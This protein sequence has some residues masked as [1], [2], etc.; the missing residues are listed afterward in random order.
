MFELRKCEKASNAFSM[1]I[2]VGRTEN[3]DV[4]VFDN[5]VSR[6]HAYFQQDRK[7]GQWMLVDAESLNGTWVGETRLEPSRPTP[8]SGRATLRF[9]EVQMLFLSPD[10]FASHLEAQV[11]AG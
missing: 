7:T 6:F 9:G 2:T 3:N 4:V 5:S 1:G 11:S 10:H 8:I